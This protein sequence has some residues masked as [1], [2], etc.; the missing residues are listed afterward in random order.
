MEDGG[1]CLIKDYNMTEAIFHVDMKSQLEKYKKKP[2]GK[3][4]VVFDGCSVDYNQENSEI[5]IA[6]L[7]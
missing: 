4:K 6:L 5:T 2:I 7:A 1:K 3:V